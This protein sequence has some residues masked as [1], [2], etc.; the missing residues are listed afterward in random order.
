VVACE[1]PGAGSNPENYRALLHLVDI[2]VGRSF[3]S[4]VWE[5]QA[6]SAER[7]GAAESGAAFSTQPRQTARVP[8]NMAVNM[9]LLRFWRRKRATFEVECS[10][11]RRT[12]AIVAPRLGA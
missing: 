10:R 1:A 2:A 4:W 9:P 3:L 6:A 11:W 12:W 7:T 5:A 8:A